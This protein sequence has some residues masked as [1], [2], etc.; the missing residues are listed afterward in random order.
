[1]RHIIIKTTDIK[2]LCGIAVYPGLRIIRLGFFKPLQALANK[3]SATLP[4]DICRNCRRSART[5]T[6]NHIKQ[7]AERSLAA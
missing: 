6:I 3:F 7:A 1:M 2:A 5:Q 4:D